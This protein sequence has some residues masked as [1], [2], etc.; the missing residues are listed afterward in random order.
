MYSAIDPIALLISSQWSLT[1]SFY[2]Q[3]SSP[4]HPEILRSRPST[5][6]FSMLYSEVIREDWFIRFWTVKSFWS[7]SSRSSMRFCGWLGLG[8]CWEI[9]SSGTGSVLGESAGVGSILDFRMFSNFI[10]FGSWRG[11]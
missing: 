5:L 10:G 9:C 8:S 2:K 4:L 6:M 11:L 3:E 7:F 1:S